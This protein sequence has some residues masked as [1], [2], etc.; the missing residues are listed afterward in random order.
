VDD[1]G[2]GDAADVCNDGGGGDV[3]VDEG[4]VAVGSGGGGGRGEGR[5]Q[6]GGGGGG[7]SVGADAVVGPHERAGLVG[8]Q[9]HVCVGHP[10]VGARG[11]EHGAGGGVDG[12][13]AKLSAAG[14]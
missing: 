5:A 12:E 10:C 7:C 4:V 6:A 11:V 14:E 13:K 2:G 1:G 3:D 9:R 8:G